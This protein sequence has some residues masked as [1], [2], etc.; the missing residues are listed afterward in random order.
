MIYFFDGT[1]EAF[2]TAMLA[3]FNDADAYLTC[4]QKQLT[5]GQQTVFV[6]AD[7][8]RAK[9]AEERL[10]AYDRG[11]MRD[12][13]LILRSGEQNRGQTAFLY[14]K[15]LAEL[16][17]PVRRML[18]D[19]AVIAATECIRR[20]TFE[21]HRL[22]GF[23]RFMESASGALYAPISPDNDICDLL[24]PHFRAR[25][26]GYPFVIH[27]VPR[28]KAAVCDGEHLFT[29]PL[30]SAEVLLSAEE[31]AWQKLWKTYY[32]SVNIPER[33]RLK[34]MLGYMPKRYWKH[35]TEFMPSGGM[36]G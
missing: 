8:P 9:R 28:K 13:D 2:L 22:H 1:K 23:V 34:Q 7:A 17:R 30:E 36:D 33:E 27:D 11:C 32:A 6:T 25:L 4:G 15:L 21:I 12:L 16:K 31:C 14:L 3:A 18:A 24:A 29:A 35:L 19:D 5:L 10:L 26:K 20:V